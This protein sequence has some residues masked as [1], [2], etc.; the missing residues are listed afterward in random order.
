MS[1]Q[2][3]GFPR[4]EYH[5]YRQ[6]ARGSPPAG[7][8]PLMRRTSLFLLLLLLTFAGGLPARAQ[9]ALEVRI[10]PP[11]VSAFPIISTLVNIYTAEG[12]F[13]A[14]LTS[15]DLSVLEDD[16]PRQVLSL[17][18]LNPGLRLVVAINPGPPLA[19]RDDLGV[20]R[21]E[22]VSR[23]LV[24]WASGLPVDSRDELA[25]VGTT[26]VLLQGGS[27]QE[28]RTTFNAYQPDS[29]LARPSLQALALALDLVS[30]T[31][32]QPGMK[33]AVLFVTPHMEQE[34]L[35]A[36]QG[37][38]QRAV[39][40]D[41]HVFIWMVDSPSYFQHSSASA[42]QALTDGTGAAYFAFSGTQTL[43]DP[44][45]YF[46]PLRH[47]YRL[48][49]ASGVNAA[50]AHTLTVNVQT[51]DGLSAMASQQ[52]LVNVQPPNP[53]LVSPPLQ[54]VRQT[55]DEDRFN[56]ETLAPNEQA[57]ELLVEFPDGYP[58]PLTRTALYVDGALVAENTAAPFETFNWDISG[59]EISGV[60]T[61]QVEA[62]DS[63]GLSRV[64]LGVPVTVTVVRPPTGL[65]AIFARY[66][67][68]LTIAAIVLA[69][70]V[71]GLILAGGR[72]R[73][74]G[75]ARRRERRLYQD[76]VTQPVPI[77]TEPRTDE[78]PAARSRF[79][80]RPRLPQ[81]PAYLVRLKPDGQPAPGNPLPLNQPEITFGTDPVKSSHVLDD[82]TISPLHARLVREPDG[83]YMLFNE[84]PVAGTWVNYQPVDRAGRELQHG[85]QVHI[86]QFLYR[87]V[88]RQ[89]P[90]REAPRVIPE[91]KE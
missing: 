41:V 33:R 10:A 3:D 50:G 70:L 58:R 7:C 52:F 71:V 88:L 13:V 69:G 80:R 64:S 25:L 26:G 17:T 21:Y 59:F 43:P 53:I 81:A 87:F 77:A 18:D 74:P 51:V 32:S 57:L 40:L 45:T 19:L 29:R 65:L 68:P 42:F 48:E 66:S 35:A 91:R 79:A 78:Q 75:Q 55:A 39:E 22:Q 31:A 82:T 9:G 56:I 62:V 84:S 14:G 67:L 20:A 72:L 73:I 6:P 54:I 38:T 1:A 24:E 12:G 8:P 47:V 90:E 27:P 30:G 16:Q 28:W 60:H 15:A 4:V 44:E 11:D 76:P 34:D 85:D 86:G 83:R 63:L 49:Y 61:L 36:L 2:V 5:S 46:E 23:R 89:P 37:L